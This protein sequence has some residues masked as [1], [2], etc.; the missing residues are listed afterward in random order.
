MSG[1]G[2]TMNT[3]LLRKLSYRSFWNRP[4]RFS[5][6]PPYA[7]GAGLNLMRVHNRHASQLHLA[8]AVSPL[9]WFA[10]IV[11]AVPTDA[12]AESSAPQT[13]I[14]SS[15]SKSEPYLAPP[16]VLLARPAAADLMKHVC[17]DPARYPARPF[18]TRQ[19]SA[20]E[21][22]A[23]FNS[24]T[25]QRELLRN[26]QILDTHDLLVQAAFLDNDVLLKFF[27]AKEITWEKPEPPTMYSKPYPPLAFGPNRVAHLRRLGGALS[28]VT[29]RVA[30]LVT[31]MGWHQMQFPPWAWWPPVTYFA[32]YMQIEFPPPDA[33]TV[34]MVREA[35]GQHLP[36]SPAFSIHEFGG[37]VS[38]PGTLTYVDQEKVRRSA[39]FA[40][41]S[42]E[43]IP[44]QSGNEAQP[45]TKGAHLFADDRVILAIHIAQHERDL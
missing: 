9:L 23:L 30:T 1:S 36:E 35:F 38:G 39:P 27:G 13:V 18:N 34:G 26:I 16:G 2:R 31:C 21:L 37:G 15:P 33:P 6:S 8:F 4:S 20:I 5:L 17:S 11:A 25:T 41:H 28:G 14:A 44:Q 43:F 45:R 7:L 40:D 42:I 24:P 10:L 3:R 32:G 29:V 19:L 12:P 22:K